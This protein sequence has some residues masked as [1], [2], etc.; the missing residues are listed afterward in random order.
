MY[1]NL[2]SPPAREPEQARTR[3]R[4]QGG[5]WMGWVTLICSVLALCLAGAAL[6]LTLRE[7]A[8]P[9]APPEPVTFQY[10]DM[11][12]EAK[13]GVPVNS[14]DPAGFTTDEL[15]RIG[16]EQDGLR[17]RAGIDVSFYQ[18]EID[19]EAVAADGVEFAMIR[20]GYRGYTEGSLQ[21]D[22]RFEENIRGARMAGLDVGV[23]FF[24][25]ASTPQEAEEEADFVVGVLAPYNIT[26]PVAFDW[27]FITQGNGARTDNLDGETLTQCAAAFCAR[28]AQAGYQPLIYF[29]QDLGYLTYDLAQLTEYPFWLAEY[30]GAPDFYYGF[31]FWQYTHAGTVAGI[32][33]H[34]DWNLDLRAFGSDPE[35]DT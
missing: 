21:L 1:D 9:P 19:W 15:G 27:E 29:N 6:Y 12:L 33:G 10:R 17:A 4:R 14:Y 5:G 30:G 7:E 34:V 2:Q 31:N 32:E 23:Y 16:Y 28:I 13:E 11:I 3:G 8:E 26:Y 20:L 24:S 18:G 22:S 25:Q 35:Q